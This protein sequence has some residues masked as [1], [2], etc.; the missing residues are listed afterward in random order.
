MAGV[1]KAQGRVLAFI[2]RRIFETGIAPT[3]EEIARVCGLAS[4]SVVAKHID[5]LVERGVISKLPGRKQ[6]IELLGHHRHRPT[7]IVPAEPPEEEFRA[8][9]AIAKTAEAQGEDFLWAFWQAMI[10]PYQREN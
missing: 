3:Y 4:K 10:E 5:A 2:Q 8:A 1:T 6:S 9:E 7:V